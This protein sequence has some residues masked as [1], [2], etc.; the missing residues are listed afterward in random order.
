MPSVQ[1]YLSGR[2]NLA[3]TAALAA[4][5]V[6]ASTAIDRVSARR[7]GGGRVRLVGSYTG[8]EAA[9]V[10]VEIISAGGVPRASVPQ[11]VGVGNGQLAVQGVDAAAAPESTTETR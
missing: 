11:F 9:G 4:S 5:S 6:R 7:T 10:D 2:D 3:R 8:H 1:R